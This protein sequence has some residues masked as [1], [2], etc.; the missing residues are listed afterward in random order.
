LRRYAVVALG[1][2]EFADCACLD[3]IRAGPTGNRPSRF[4]GRSG[5]RP[6]HPHQCLGYPGVSVGGPILPHTPAGR[7]GWSRRVAGRARRAA[8][9]ASAWRTTDLTVTPPTSF[10]GLASRSKETVRPLLVEHIRQPL[11]ILTPAFHVPLGAPSRRNQVPTAR[12]SDT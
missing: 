11:G 3:C 2:P 7:S 5:R 8:A 10:G 9:G 4:N 6:A 12:R 1:C